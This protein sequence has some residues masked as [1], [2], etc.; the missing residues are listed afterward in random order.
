[1]CKDQRESQPIIDNYKLSYLLITLNRPDLKWYNIYI[2]YL[3]VLQYPQL[4]RGILSPWKGL[5]LYGPPGKDL[6]F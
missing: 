1:M 6:M 2:I 4:F 3:S 5:L